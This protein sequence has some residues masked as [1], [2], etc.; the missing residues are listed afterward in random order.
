MRRRFRSFS[1]R[2]ASLVAVLAC[3]P[4]PAIADPGAAA[5]VRVHESVATTP[6]SIRKEAARVAHYWT[7]ARMRSAWP[8]DGGFA[9][10]PTGRPFLVKPRG[11]V[12]TASYAGVPD[13]SIPPFPVNGRLFLRQG[14]IRA[15]CSGTAINS[16]TRQLVLTAGH[17]VN[18]GPLDRERHNIWSQYLAFVPAYND[19]V[20][21]FGVFVARRGAV[22]ASRSWVRGGNPNFDIGAFLTNPNAG[23]QNVAD[24]VGGGATIVT[25][26]N[27]QQQFQTFGYPGKVRQLQECDS[28]YVG[29]D[30]LTYRLPGPPTMA[31]DCYWRPGSSGG[32]WLISNGTAIDGLTSYSHRH[33]H[34]HTFSPYFG[35]GNVGK[36]V[37]NL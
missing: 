31:I 26:Q 4:A 13:S 12:A 14:P 22:Y 30:V 34:T 24:A 28:P 1:L 23:G 10:G 25:D 36:L 11:S 35:S 32:G 18:S 15:Y 17:C 21:P 33:N 8:L 6:S 3:L 2:T 19:G 20:A 29:D 7:P 5:A 37:A 16:P 9:G 27:R